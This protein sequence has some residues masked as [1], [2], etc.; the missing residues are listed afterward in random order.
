ML[1]GRVAMT[2]PSRGVKPVVVSIERP[3]RTAASDAP[4]PRWQVTVRVLPVS[5]AVRLAA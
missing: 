2:S 5:A 1:P 3:S 4:A